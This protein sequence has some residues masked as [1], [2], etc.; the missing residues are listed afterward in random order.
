[1]NHIPA[2]QPTGHNQ[3]LY[4]Y[5]STTV[6][7]AIQ[8]LKNQRLNAQHEQDDCKTMPP[9]DQFPGAYLNAMFSD[10]KSTQKP[11]LSTA[12]GPILLI[13]PVEITTQKNWHF[14]VIDQN[15]MINQNT[16]CY[17]TI[18]SMPNLGDVA[19]FYRETT[20]YYP[21]NECIIHDGLDT[22]LLKEIWVKDRD[23]KQQLLHALKI[24]VPIK[25]V[26]RMTPMRRLCIASNQNRF[27]DMD[28]KPV[29]TYFL[30]FHY[31]GVEFPRY[32]TEKNHT[33][34]RIQR[35]LAQNA[36]LSKVEATKMQ[37]E[38]LDGFIGK[39]ICTLLNSRLNR[40]NVL[41]WPPFD[42]DPI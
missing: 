3:L 24:E 25:I 29:F 21:G 28:A 4:F 33:P 11:K 39:R 30:D 10:F 34:I 40:P 20:G 1:M 17:K 14:N 2:D 18:D 5:H 26:N 8:I 9:P 32:I 35:C 6:L 31:T 38:A 27:L 15:G 12:F 42:P 13:F 16:F 23:A 7:K 22:R 37:V 36:G 19:R 41:Y